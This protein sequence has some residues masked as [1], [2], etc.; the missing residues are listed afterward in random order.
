MK[1][2]CYVDFEAIGDDPDI[3]QHAVLSKAYRVLHGAFG[4]SG[5]KY[6]VA[7]PGAKEGKS[8]SVGNVIRVF[9]DS[10]AELYSLLEKVRGHHVMRDYARVTMPQDVPEDFSGEWMSWQRIRVQKK[11]GVNR[12]ATIKRA[13]ESPYFEVMS[14]S[15]NSFPLRIHKVKADPQLEDF[16]PNSYGLSTGGNRKGD[17]QNLF[18]LPVL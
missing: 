14:S 17:G 5:G 16:T 11:E 4:G 9:A 10:S 13:N 1:A 15:E 2:K 8:R 12:V 18:S 3:P 7:F 6:A